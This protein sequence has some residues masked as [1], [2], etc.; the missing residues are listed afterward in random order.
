MSNPCPLKLQ[1]AENA[2]AGRRFGL[3][4]ARPRLLRVPDD[5]VV[6]DVY[7]KAS[8]DEAEAKS[9]YGG[10]LWIGQYGEALDYDSVERRIIETT[11]AT[12]RAPISPHDFRRNA[13]TTAAFR[14]GSEPHLGNGLLQ[15]TGSRTREEHYNRASNLTAAV[16]FGRMVS[17][18][19]KP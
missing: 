11:H 5:R 17:H 8:H 2:G 13:A 1:W 3:T 19:R 4:W 14:A 10:P 18:L 9:S 16:E 15:H 12:L 6:G 7:E